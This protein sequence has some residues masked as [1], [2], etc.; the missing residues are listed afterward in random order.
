[1]SSA[2]LQ[3]LDTTIAHLEALKGQ[4]VGWVPVRRDT[5]LSVVSPSSKRSF[6]DRPARGFQNGEARH[7]RFSECFYSTREVGLCSFY[8][9]AFGSSD[10]CPFRGGD[11]AV[12]QG[13][14]GSSSSV[15][16]F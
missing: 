12:V 11:V 14:C 13:G 16:E 7:S 1:M 10:R 2:Y 5:L 9:S 8:A 4:G 6:T 15:I 3:L